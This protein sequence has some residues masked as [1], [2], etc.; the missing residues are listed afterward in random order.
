MLLY[1]QL[2]SL[3]L[4]FTTAM[5]EAFGGVVGDELINEAIVVRCTNPAFGDFQF[6]NSM[7]IAKALKSDSNYKGKFIAHSQ[8]GTFC[9]HVTNRL[10]LT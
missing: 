7:S 10:K 4:I 8:V 5:Q 1:L 6:N 9:Q 2:S 3:R